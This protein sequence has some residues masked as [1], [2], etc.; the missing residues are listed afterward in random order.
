MNQ[1]LQKIVKEHQIRLGPLDDW[2]DDYVESVIQSACE[3]YAAKSNS[4]MFP[5]IGGP[6][7]P[8]RVIAPCE[9]QAQQ[10]HSQ[11]FQRLAERGGLSP[12][13]A[14]A[15]LESRRWH[16]MDK[17]Q[18]L[19]RLAEIVKER[20][21]QPII[22]QLR[23]QV[24]GLTRE[25]DHLE[26]FIERDA[27]QT[28][29][30]SKLDRLQLTAERDTLRAQLEKSEKAN[31]NLSKLAST[32]RKEITAANKGA[33]RNAHISSNL[34]DKVI[35][36][37]SE[38]EKAQEQLAKT[39]HHGNQVSAA[40]IDE[41]HKLSAELD[42]AQRDR[43]L[44]KEHSD[45]MEKQRDIYKAELDKAKEVLRRS[46]VHDAYRHNGY[47]QMTT[48]QKKLYCSIIGAEFTPLR[49]EFHESPQP[50]DQSK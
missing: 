11:S 37:R 30:W 12:C 18:A 24:E 44:F 13:E 46:S 6:A 7:I 49:P 38:L 14:V 16:P 50:K 34:T 28:P 32:Y 29:E 42:K 20:D 5:I 10:N 33:E 21:T 1:E 40:Y 48:E 19:N 15:V 8:W 45:V 25:R 9:R 4:Q 41:N 31:E 26:A 22:D 17:Q 3:K 2:P 47:L 23:Q 39:I 36:L 43:E 27:G 35:A